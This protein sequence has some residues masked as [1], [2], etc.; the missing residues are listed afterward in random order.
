[1]KKYTGE[2]IL[3]SITLIWGGTFVIVKAALQDVSPVLFVTIR[4]SLAALLL[5]PFVF[6]VIKKMDRKVITGGILL[7][8]IYFLEFVAQI[9]GLKYTTATK[10][11]FITGSFILFTPVFQLLLEKKKPGGGNLLGVLFVI[12][13]L[14]FLSS[15]GTSIFEIFREIGSGFNIGDFLTLLSAAALG[16]YIVCLDII[17]RKQDYLLLAFMQM[18][19]T[20]VCGVILT[21]FLSA[22]NLEPAE[23]SFNNNVLLAVLYTGILATALATTLQTKYQKFVTPTK[24]GIIFSFEPV[25][26]AAFA[27]FIIN[28]RISYLGFLGG[29][30]IFAGL[31]VT[32]LF[33]EIKPG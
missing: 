9:V 26:A 31:L 10:S 16:A 6:K 32:E 17:S 19:V 22:A 27:Y 29:A 13:G 15:S 14:I 23:F 7:G 18:G 2:T 11:G 33:N 21:V 1:M 25:F 30:L 20:A 4:F 8:L 24:A 5:L 28:E 3:L 12:S